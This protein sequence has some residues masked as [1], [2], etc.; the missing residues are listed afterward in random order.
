MRGVRHLMIALLIAACGEPAANPDAGPLAPAEDWDRDILDTDLA[1]DLATREAT[2]TLTLAASESTGA[3]FEIGDL[4]ITSVT[5]AT[6]EPL[7]H[8]VHDAQLDVGV[9]AGTEPVTVVVAYRFTYHDGF[10]GADDEPP[11]TLTWPYYCGNVFPCKTKANP[12]DGTRFTL[13]LSGV[14]DGA[15]AVYPAAIEEPAPAYMLAWS[16]DAYTKLELGTTPAGTDVSAW[17]LGINPT[18]IQAGTQHL[19]AAIGWME[20]HL[21]D[22]AFGDEI[23]AVAA[24]WGLGAFGGMEHHP[25]FHVGTAAIAS[26]EVMAHEA[27]HGW[28]GDGVRLRCWEDFTLSEGTVTYLA[29]RVLGEVGDQ[30][31]EDSVWAEYENRLDA[32]AASGGGGIAW[33]DSCGVVDILDLFNFSDAPYIKGAYFYRAVAERVG[34]AVLD[35]VLGTFYA[36]HRTEAAGMQDMLDT[37]EAETGWDPTACAEG[38]LRSEAI[39]AD[40]SCP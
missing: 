40:R 26:E 38:W 3:S 13:E 12:A 11:L 18:N 7:L 4:E 21:G 6:G 28:Y 29:A 19:V 10:T 15:V 20:E 35:D 8:D 23:G 34:E 14:P 1:I 36:A 37:I 2:A 30:A 39:P 25:F 31:L 33:P 24:R 16:I 32:L 9:P 27:A 5:D 22:Y 17:Y